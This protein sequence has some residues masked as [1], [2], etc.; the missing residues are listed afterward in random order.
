MA[1]LYNARRDRRGQRSGFITGESKSQLIFYPE[2]RFEMYRAIRQV[3]KP[4]I[5][6]KILAG[7]QVFFGKR[8][9]EFARV[10][11]GYI[12]EAYESIKPGDAACVGVLQRD[13]DQLEENARILRG[14]L[15]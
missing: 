9:D 8:P 11:E 13:G 7:G 15:G 3:Q 4:F 2:D 12:R 10:A 1:C 5:A 14:A 6:Y